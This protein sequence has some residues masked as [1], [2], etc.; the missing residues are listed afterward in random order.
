VCITDNQPDTESNPN[1]NP[2]PTAKQH[3]VVSIQVNIVTCSHKYR[4]AKRNSYRGL[5]DAVALFQQLSVV[6]VTL[7][8]ID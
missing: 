7:P 3:A 1:P 6:I 5:R 2:Q 4:R 8:M